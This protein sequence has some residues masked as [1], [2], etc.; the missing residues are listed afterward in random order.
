MNEK[1]L[2][3]RYFT[4]G[5]TPSSVITGIGDD[6]AVL[7]PGGQH[8]LVVTTDTMLAGV[9]FLKTA[10]AD[11]IGYK[12][13]ASSISDVAAMAALPRWATLNITLDR[14]DSAWLRAF[15]KGLFAC[16]DKHQ[17][18]LVGGDTTRGDHLVLSL[19]LMAEAP[20]GKALLRSNAKAGDQIFVSGEIG[21]AAHALLKLKKA[22]NNYSKLERAHL[23]ALFRPP[24]RVA[25]GLAIRELAHAAID[26]SDGFLHELEIICQASQVGASISLENLPVNRLIPL[27]Q[28]ITGGE[29]YELL[30]TADP[31]YTRQILALSAEHNCPISRVGEIKASRSIDLYY[32][33][34]RLT[35]PARTGYDHFQSVNRD[36]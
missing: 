33:G 14:V 2:I 11:D 21:H 8:E 35:M 26:I 18:T 32:G 3:Q 24:S 17:V 9:H 13:M 28:A 7:L 23:S 19:Q 12:L 34:K 5:H 31:E 16:A 25:L 6:A 30:F 1:Q 15:S 27:Q 36:G 29:D 4:A 22:N 10:R 20:A